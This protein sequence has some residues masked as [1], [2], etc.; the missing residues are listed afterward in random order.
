MGPREL[1]S[2]PG[3]K[4]RL[5]PGVVGRRNHNI[6]CT[7]SSIFVAAGTAQSFAVNGGTL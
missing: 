4:W 5:D 7:S 6:S 2:G 1:M 3:L